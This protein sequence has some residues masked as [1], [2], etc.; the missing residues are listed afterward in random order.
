MKIGSYEVDNRWVGVGGIVLLAVIVFIFLSWPSKPPPTPTV[1]INAAQE[2][3]VK[4]L[5][6]TITDKTNQVRDYQARLTVSEGKYRA[7][8]QKYVDLQK[9]K[10]DVK[11]PTTNKELRDRFVALGYAP[12]AASK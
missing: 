4:Q 3:I 9:V 2:A 5:N 12:L 6:Q 8:S 1:A 10:E 11:A 7:L